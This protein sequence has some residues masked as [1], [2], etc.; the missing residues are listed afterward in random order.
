MTLSNT[1]E[2]NDLWLFLFNKGLVNVI[3]IV[4][5]GWSYKTWEGRI[6]Q[7]N[8][9][10]HF[11]YSFYEKLKATGN[12]LFMAPRINRASK[13]PDFSGDLPI[14]DKIMKISRSPDLE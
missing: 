4:V 3:Q 14:F 11:A 10:P 6:K 13:S 1:W 8:Y 9:L 7:Y 12:L 5:S 2:L